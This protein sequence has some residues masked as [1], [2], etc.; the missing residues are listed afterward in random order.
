MQCKSFNNYIEQHEYIVKH[1]LNCLFM[2]QDLHTSSNMCYI[3][4]FEDF[5]SSPCVVVGFHFK[6]VILFFSSSKQNYFYNLFIDLLFLKVWF[7]LFG[8]EEYFYFC[9]IIVFLVVEKPHRHCKTNV[10]SQKYFKSLNGSRDI[11]VLHFI[12][13]KCFNHPM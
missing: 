5:L 6:C 7:T 10:Y 4:I 8:I 2:F 3:V 1:R 9:Y 13:K 12:F 11:M